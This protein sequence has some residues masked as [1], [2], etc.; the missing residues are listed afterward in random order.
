MEASRPP[1]ALNSEEPVI[2]AA[3]APARHS[4]A[5]TRVCRRV[6]VEEY[7]LPSKSPHDRLLLHA[8]LLLTQ[9]QLVLFTGTIKLLVSFVLEE[10][11]GIAR[12]DT[13]WIVFS[14]PRILRV[15]AES[16]PPSHTREIMH[17]ELPPVFSD[18]IRPLH[19]FPC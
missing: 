1:P 14:S 7:R 6:S 17:R 12:P 16:V 10:A 15:F 13:G 19:Q 8:V 5:P 18:L 2:R 11:Q 9:I 3:L 4:F